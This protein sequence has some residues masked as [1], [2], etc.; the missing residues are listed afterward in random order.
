MEKIEKNILD[1][2]K[3]CSGVYGDIKNDAFS[4][5]VWC[6]IHDYSISSPIEQML[7]CALKI[8]QEMAYINVA[9]PI[10]V[11]GKWYSVGLGII[12][13]FKIKNYKVDFLV[14]YGSHITQGNQKDKKEIV[15]ECDSKQFHD[16][17]NEERRLEKQRER[18]IVA[19][20]YKIFRFTGSEIVKNPLKVA[21]EIIGYLTDL[22]EDYL[23]DEN[24]WEDI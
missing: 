24:Y 2:I 19:N 17:T 5:D 4:Q 9:E 12:P 8:V 6:Q 14:H 18:I 16:R 13:Q 22:E 7:F 15:V 3:K 10:E 21:S 20:G 23:I 1:F 11:N